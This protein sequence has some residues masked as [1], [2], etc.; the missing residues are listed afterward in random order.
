MENGT[1]LYEVEMNTPLGPRKGNL[2]LIMK[3][4]HTIANNP[5][6]CIEYVEACR[7]VINRMC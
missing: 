1:Y 7:R 2:E 6:N 3:D 4:T 5:Q